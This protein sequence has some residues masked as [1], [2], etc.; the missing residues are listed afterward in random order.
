MRALLLFVLLGVFATESFGQGY[1]R[2]SGYL[3]RRWAVGFGASVSLSRHPQRVLTDS[4]ADGDPTQVL[5]QPLNASIPYLS[6]N[7]SFQGHIEFAAGQQLLL[8]L[9]GGYAKTSAALSQGTYED[10]AWAD[11]STSLVQYFLSYVSGS[12]DIVDT[13]YGVYAKWYRKKKGG[14]APVGTYIGGGLNRHSYTIDYTGVRFYNSMHKEYTYSRQKE[15]R[16][17]TEAFV[18][19]GKAIPWGKR[20]VTDFS[21]K[22]GF[23]LNGGYA[24]I[25]KGPD[26]T[27][28]NLDTYVDHQIK[29]RLRG[30]CFLNYSI[31]FFVLIA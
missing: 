29:A 19:L 23:L 11:S 2:V 24:S 16:S 28:D 30:A 12:P 13:Y 15:K 8:G 10:F 25:I 5:N 17:Y 31:R 7:R 1:K 6:L 20:F 14:I 18:E 4:I 22:G 9:R 21:V 27:N 26:H 3:G